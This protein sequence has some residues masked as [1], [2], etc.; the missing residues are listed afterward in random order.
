M[1]HRNGTMKVLLALALAAALPSCLYP[2]DRLAQN[3]LPPKE[4]I[5]NLQQAID[6]F[7]ADNGLLP[8]KNAEETTPRYEKF[9][10]D[11]PKLRRMN[12]IGEIPAAAFEKGGSYYFLIQNEESDPTVKLMSVVVYQQINDLQRRVDAYKM[13]NGGRLPVGEQAYPS[14]RYLD[15]DKLKGVKLDIRSVYSRQPMNVIVHEGGTVFADYGIDVRKAV[16][17]QGGTPPGPD[18]DLRGLL[19]A[20][21]DF[22]PVKSPAY[23]LVNGDP[24]ARL[25][26]PLP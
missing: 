4:A 20:K 19:V 2:Q 1:G 11:L 17:Q 5:R 14:F 22:V 10:V 9:I 7:Q 16:E 18:Y 23:Y 24:E 3:Q 12:Y 8:I 15:Y 25:P 26:V 13:A 21:S 6:Q